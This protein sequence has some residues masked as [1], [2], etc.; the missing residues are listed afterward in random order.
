MVFDFHVCIPVA[1][2]SHLAWHQR[3]AALTGT[4]IW[5]S[6]SPCL[7]RLGAL[8]LL[9]FLP[10][11]MCV[12]SWWPRPLVP[13][14]SYPPTQRRLPHAGCVLLLSSADVHKIRP[15]TQQFIFAKPLMVCNVF[16]E[17]GYCGGED[18]KSAQRYRSRCSNWACQDVQ[19]RLCCGIKWIVDYLCTQMLRKDFQEMSGSSFHLYYGDASGTCCYWS[20]MAEMMQ[21][22]KFVKNLET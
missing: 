10:L 7:A 4:L 21:T 9:S 5:G 16:L 6:C 8:H 2:A 11:T 14:H 3:K 1:D 19:I 12:L 20:F 15:G 22:C 17:V 18:S 13:S